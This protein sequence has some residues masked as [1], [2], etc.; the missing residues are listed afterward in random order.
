MSVVIDASVALKW[1]L[2]EADSEAA[3]ALIEG[4][5]SAPDF[6]I[7]ECANILWTRAR[8]GMLTRD[9][10]RAGLVLIRSAPVNLFS[11]PAYANSAQSIA[12]ELGQSVYDSLYLAVAIAERATMITA[13]VRFVRAAS[14]HGLYAASVR[15]LENV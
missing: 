3:D 6:L 10:A 12:F 13:D 9:E 1:V 7:V 15:L 14:Q 5:M 2:R 8:R 4:P 11:A